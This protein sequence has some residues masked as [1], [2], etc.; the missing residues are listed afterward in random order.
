MSCH[1]VR[2]RLIGSIEDPPNVAV[3]PDG[4]FPAR[5]FTRIAPM[6]MGLPKPVAGLH[7]DPSHRIPDRL[8]LSPPER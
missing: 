4:D 1:V 8:R 2:L 5:T 6:V 7:Y 3:Q